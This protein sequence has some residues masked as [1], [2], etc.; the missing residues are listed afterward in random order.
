MTVFLVFVTVF[1]VA[2]GLAKKVMSRASKARFWQIIVL[3]GLASMVFGM[4]V[5]SAISHSH[6]VTT[7]KSIPLQTIEG[8]DGIKINGFDRQILVK[9]HKGKL[10]AFLGYQAGHSARIL[11][12]TT[13]VKASPWVFASR[14][15]EAVLYLPPKSIKTVKIAISQ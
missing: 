6:Q 14:R 4:I 5:T 13:E 15:T 8:Y 1:L 10:W 2:V 3:V 12:V 9:D 11:I 7:Y